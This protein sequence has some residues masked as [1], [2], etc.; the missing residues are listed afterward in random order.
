LIGQAIGQTLSF[1]IGVALSPMPIILVVLMLGAPNGRAGALAFLA[2]WIVGLAA[3]G[4]IVLVIESG[5]EAGEGGTPAT[6][7]SILT[8]GLGFALVVLA[9]KQRRARPRGEAEPELPGWMK[10]VDTFS[11]AKSAGTAALLGGVKPKN[12]IL[13][14]GACTAIAQIGASTASQAVALAT[15]IAVA[16]AGVASPIVIYF[17]TGDR[18]SA[19]L[20]DVRDWLTRENATIIAVICLIIGVKLIGDAIGALST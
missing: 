3:V 8:L 6:W 11:P 7:A 18:A 16:S 2:G 10:T 20:T 17:S 14:I 19:I 12:L 1:G 13:T 15:F 9:A 4:T 5:A